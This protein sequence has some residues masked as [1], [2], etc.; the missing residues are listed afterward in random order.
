VISWHG[1]LP[2]S[3][4]AGSG[5]GRSPE[6]GHGRAP[7]FSGREP[8]K[9]LAA[10]ANIESIG[11]DIPRDRDDKF[12]LKIVFEHDRRVDGSKPP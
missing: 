10:L 8:L 5:D 7:L 3:S 4:R 9:R 11:L 6:L 2:R 1:L 12:T